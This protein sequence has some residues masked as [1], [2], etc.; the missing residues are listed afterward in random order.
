M[1]N[2]NMYFN[3]FYPFNNYP[4][5]QNWPYQN[6]NNPNI[7]NKIL[8]DSYNYICFDCCKRINELK[9]FDLKNAV[10]LCYNCSIQHLNMPKEI[11]EIMIVDIRYLN[12]NYLLP[13]Y[14]GGNRN[15]LTFISTHFPLV[16]KIEKRKIYTNI[17]MDYY[18]KLLQSKVY[19]LP[20]PNLPSK[21]EVYDSIYMDI[22]NSGNESSYNSFRN[23]KEEEKNNDKRICNNIE[24]IKNDQNEEKKVNALFKNMKEKKENVLDEIILT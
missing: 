21:F 20:E 6:Y 24:D 1:F 7:I 12:E 5:G 2:N 13:L 15:L 16:E 10:F 4:Y 17:F 11:S 23:N 22:I 8:S 18:R 19:N 3:N 9:Y 14:H